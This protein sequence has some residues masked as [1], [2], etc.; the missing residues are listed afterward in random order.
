[1]LNHDEVHIWQASLD[2]S[3]SYVQYLEQVLSEDE[4]IRARRFYF[5]RHNK[6]FIVGRGLLRM[7]LGGYLHIEP[8]SLQFCYTSKGKPALTK[9]F[10]DSMISFNLS[11]SHGVAVYAITYG[12]KIGIDIERIRPISY[13]E[14]I[15]DRFFSDN[16]KTVFR[17]LPD[18]QKLRGFFNC[19]TRK[20]AYLKAVGDGLAGSLDKFEV[21]ITPG[22]Q[23]RLL[24]IEGEP[25]EVSRWS[26][27]D[28][29]PGSGYAA[30]LAV[31]GH[32][33]HIRF[34]QWEDGSHEN[35]DQL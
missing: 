6:Y 21:T 2:Q 35:L 29:A 3:D 26:I 20:E 30:A 27:H 13:A 16:E 19:W 8:C 33:W 9:L 18:H 23:A 15:A 17:S 12:R 7:I 10:G 22:E 14:R 11:H 31:E 32:D 24:H 4:Q 28:L 1:M 25:Q 34:R 5:E